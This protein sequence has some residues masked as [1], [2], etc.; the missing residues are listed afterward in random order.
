M[1]VDLHASAAHQLR[2][3]SWEFVGSVSIRNSCCREQSDGALTV[4]SHARLECLRGLSPSN[5][6]MSQFVVTK[7]VQVSEIADA[8][9]PAAISPGD[10]GFTTCD[11]ATLRVICVFPV[12]GVNELG[13][14]DSEKS[15]TD[16]ANRAFAGGLGLPF[17]HS[18][19]PVEFQKYVLSNSRPPSMTNICG[20]LL[21][22]RT[23]SRSVIMQER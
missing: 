8:T 18:S 17:M 9:P 4:S 11:L 23:H 16:R 15:F 2:R 22:R 12:Q 13:V 14:S 21:K 1:L 5:G 10:L 20:N 6:E 19:A 3:S 7:F